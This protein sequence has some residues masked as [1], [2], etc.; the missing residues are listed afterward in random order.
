MQFPCFDVSLGF[1]SLLYCPPRALERIFS[2]APRVEDPGLPLVGWSHLA[3]PRRRS[4]ADEEFPAG[5]A[6]RCLRPGERGAA[7]AGFRNV[8]SSFTHSAQGIQWVERPESPSEF[9][10]VCLLH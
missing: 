4:K 2:A 7:L 6:I 3:V 8:L 10:S 1:E 9:A 5:S